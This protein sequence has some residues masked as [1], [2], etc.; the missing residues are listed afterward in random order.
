MGQNW[1][2]N[3][4]LEKYNRPGTVVLLYYSPIFAILGAYHKTENEMTDFQKWPSIENT[5]QDKNLEY[6]LN[7]YPELSDVDYVIT[8]KLHGSNFQWYL[9]A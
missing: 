3:V 6:W 2:L 1:L 7:Q 8:E 5:Y 4:L 9:A